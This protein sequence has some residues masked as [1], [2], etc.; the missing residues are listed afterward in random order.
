MGI[1]YDL[2][3]RMR[4]YVEVD[5]RMTTLCKIVQGLSNEDVKEI[6]FVAE[7]TSICGFYSTSKVLDICIEE[8]LRGV[9]FDQTKLGIAMNRKKEG[10]LIY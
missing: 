3:E 6:R 1:L 2:N 5:E 10:W 4:S 9:T 8:L 7:H